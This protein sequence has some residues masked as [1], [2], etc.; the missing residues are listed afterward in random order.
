[1][2]ARRIGDRHAAEHP[3]D[4]FDSIG[5]LKIADSGLSPF[6]IALLAYLQMLGAERGDLR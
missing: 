2:F 5:A 1:V 4:F 3:R 6:A